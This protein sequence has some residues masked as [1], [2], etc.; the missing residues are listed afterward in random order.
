M[1]STFDVLPR[2][3]ALGSFK[4][5]GLS[6][7]FDHLWSGLLLSPILKSKGHPHGKNHFAD[8]HLCS[9]L[10]SSRP[11]LN[12][13]PH[14]CQGLCGQGDLLWGTCDFSPLFKVLGT[15]HTV[16]IRWPFANL[17]ASFDVSPYVD[18]PP[19][20][21]QLSGLRR[22]F[23]HLRYP[24]AIIPHC[25]EKATQKRQSYAADFTFIGHF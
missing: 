6:R 13:P 19:P 16:M 2:F 17:W 15:P 12:P 14:E 22:Q 9:H 8:L 24:C 3:H 10:S 1:W 20:A 21:P 11:A 25:E 23:H 18:A 7:Q 5:Q 4:W